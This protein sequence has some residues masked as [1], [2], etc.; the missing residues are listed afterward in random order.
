MSQNES[1]DPVDNFR[2]EGRKLVRCFGN[3]VF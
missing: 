3:T 2:I 1:D